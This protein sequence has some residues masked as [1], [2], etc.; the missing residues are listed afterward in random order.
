MK[1]YIHIAKCVKPVLSSDASRV[2]AEEYAKLRNANKDDTHMARTQPITARC[3]ETLIRLST[4]HAKAR[5]SKVISKEDAEAAIDLLH[6]AIFKRVL[7][8]E[9]K[10]RRRQNSGEEGGS[11]S[12]A[13]HGSEAGDED[14]ENRSPETSDSQ[15]RRSKRS[16]QQ[17]D[18]PY[19]ADT[20]DTEEVMELAELRKKK[21][22]QPDTTPEVMETDS[23]PV[24]E[25]REI[26]KDR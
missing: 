6:F 9:K 10:R 19:D 4:A 25:K 17:S 20:I 14:I 11:E 5:M 2:I 8:K 24:S 15:P 7:E 18:D 13:E 21:D 22:T 12:E 23:E 16:K 26:S 1:K 3:L